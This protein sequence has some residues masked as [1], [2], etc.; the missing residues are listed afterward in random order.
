MNILLT[1]LYVIMTIIGIGAML[2]VLGFLVW[3][4]FGF[5]CM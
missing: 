5:W 2:L 4:I 1:I 3:L